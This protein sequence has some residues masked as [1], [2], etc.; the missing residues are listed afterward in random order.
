MSNRFLA[1]LRNIFRSQDGAVAIHMGILTV[2]LIGMI[3]LAVEIGFVYYKQ[4]QMQSAADAAAQGA[5]VA[6]TKT[7]PDPTVEAHALAAAVGY[8]NGANGVTITVNRPP[9]SG[10]HVGDTN[11]VEV[12]IRQPQDLVLASLVSRWYGSAA[13]SWVVTARAVALAGQSGLYCVVALDT[14]ACGSVHLFN[15]ASLQTSPCDHKCGVA[16]NSSCGTAIILDNNAQIYGPV[17]TDGNWSL[18][19]GAR[20]NCPP[21]K[22]GASSVIDPYATVPLTAPSFCLLSTFVGSNKTA[23]IL[24]GCY[25]N[26]TVGNSSTLN[27]LPG[28][29]WIKAMTLGN[30]NK[31]N[32]T[33]VT[34]VFTGILGSGL[35]IGNNTIFNITAPTSGSYAG[36]AIA[37]ARNASPGTVER[38]SNGAVLNLTGSIYF[39]SQTLQF[40]NNAYINSTRCTQLVA[41]KVWLAN[42]AILQ[43]DCPSIG[44]G[45]FGSANP[46]MVE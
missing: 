2:V 19:N 36:I 18:G 39:P 29:Y 42:N 44:G 31:I 23:L 7:Y 25:S 34:L 10:N 8:V 15:N 45:T 26:I 22:S 21:N 40:D 5:A 3:A 35:N 46:T 32:G 9:A 41:Q 43:N 38:F 6:I 11:A 1:L 4:R 12:I 13:P 33:G 28:V 27:L 14:T 30:S 24:P 20:L 16:A 37:G 17:T